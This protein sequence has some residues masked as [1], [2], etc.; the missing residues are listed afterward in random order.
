MRHPKGI[1][2]SA[3]E[4]RVKSYHVHDGKSLETLRSMAEWEVLGGQC[5]KCG[6]VGWLNR[7]ALIVKIGNEYLLNLRR[8]LSCHA[9]GRKGEQDVLIGHLDRN[10]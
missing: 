2:L 5:T 6:H 7:K 3:R 4:Y 8:K 9:C 10:I 1:D